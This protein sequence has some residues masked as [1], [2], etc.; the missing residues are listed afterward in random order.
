MKLFE[1][2]KVNS[3][4]SWYAN[5]PLVHSREWTYGIIRDS[6]SEIIEDKDY[7]HNKLKTQRDTG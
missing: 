2:V 3:R 4:V 6:A 1:I 5:A 7:Y